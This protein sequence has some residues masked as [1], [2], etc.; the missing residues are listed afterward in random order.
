M[1]NNLHE[2]VG[3]QG[4]I[5][6][7]Q[8]KKSTSFQTYNS[9]CFWD[10]NPLF[11][12]ANVLKSI[13]LSHVLYNRTHIDTHPI[14]LLYLLIFLFT[15]IVFLICFFSSYFFYKRRN[16]FCTNDEISVWYFYMCIYLY[17][18]KNCF[19]FKKKEKLVFLN[20]LFVLI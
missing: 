10:S 1:V 19:L 7:L 20:L 11:K 3:D 5:S 2:N 14:F 4:E 9:F 15:W 17:D 6:I 16:S 12:F 8:K 18:S 13:D